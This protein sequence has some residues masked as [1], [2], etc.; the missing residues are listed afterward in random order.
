MIIKFKIF[1][2]QDDECYW[3]IRIYLTKG[4]MYQAFRKLDVT[5]KKQKLDFLAIVMPQ[6]HEL[7][8]IIKG[9]RKWVR[10]P[11]LG[12]ALFYENKCGSGILAHEA[13]HLAMGY[14]R[15][16]DP[17]RLRYNK[18]HWEENEELLAETVGDCT[19]AL[20]MG[21]NKG[22]SMLRKKR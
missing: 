21:I 14:W 13:V 1:P 10:K 12:Y 17:K 3:E 22:L 20:K 5:G 11:L 4:R 15:H 18:I 9:K 16:R 8:L 19:E 6:K 7:L 2:R